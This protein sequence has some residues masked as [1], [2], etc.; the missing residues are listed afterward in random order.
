[1]PH[2]QLYSRVMHKMANAYA[3]VNSEQNVLLWLQQIRLLQVCAL[4]TRLSGR[5]SGLRF[6]SGL[7]PFLTFTHRAWS[8]FCSLGLIT[9]CLTSKL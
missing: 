6:E 9:C 8:H 4:R 3:A 1:M 7:E 5:L 2:V